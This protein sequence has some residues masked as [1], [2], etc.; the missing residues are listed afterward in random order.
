MAPP[1]YRMGSTNL[2]LEES[3][4]TN[5]E[6]DSAVATAQGWKLLT[7][8]LANEPDYWVNG[9][10][11]K[12]DYHPSTNW[13]QAGELV[14]KYKID[15]EYVDTNWEATIWDL[16][17]NV[18]IAETAADT[19]QRAICLAVLAAEGMSNEQECGIGEIK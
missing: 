13:Q 17:N 6:L 19:P 9:N 10:I 8:D 15:L 4:M 1:V 14:E 11:Y 7:G 3:E 5:E 18:P 16:L 12:C 2:N